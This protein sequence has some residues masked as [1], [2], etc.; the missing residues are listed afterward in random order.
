MECGVDDPKIWH[1]LAKKLRQDHMKTIHQFLSISVAKLS[2]GNT[3]PQSQ[4]KR[5]GADHLH[6][7][8]GNGSHPGM[9][10]SMPRN[11]TGA[12]YNV[13]QVYG[14][15]VESQTSCF[16]GGKRCNANGAMCSSA[17]SRTL[18]M[19]LEQQSEI[20]Y[21]QDM[22]L[23][24]QD[25]SANW[26]VGA[27]KHV[28]DLLCDPNIFFGIPTFGNEVNPCKGKDHGSSSEVREL[29][30]WELLPDDIQ[31]LVLKKL[32]YEHL[33]QA[34]LV[35]R[36]MKNV[37][38]SPA[39]LSSREGPCTEGLL[40]CL[41]F[42]VKDGPL[43]W[44]GFDLVLNE[45]RPLPTLSCL[46]PP[47]VDLFK[48][49]L[50]SASSGLLC[51]N[52]S[53]S[54][55]NEEELVVCN[56]MTQCSRI[57]PPLNFRRNPVLM[58]LL[59]DPK[60]NSYKVIVA[61]S[62]GMMTTEGHDVNLS[63]KTE[64]FDSLTSQWEVTGDMPGLEFGLNEYQTG[65]C[66]NGILY[67]ISY[68]EDGSG[69][70]AVAYD[71][72]AGDWLSDWRCPLPAPGNANS[73]LVECDGEVYLFSE[74]ENVRAVEHRIYKLENTAGESMCRWKHVV[75]DK[76]TG[77]RGLLVYPQ[78]A[79]VGFGAGKLCIF[80]TIEHTGKV[81]DIRN[82]GD[83]ELPPPPVMSCCKGGEKLFHSLNPLS[84]TFAPD[85]RTRVRHP[86]T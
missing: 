82:G 35:S 41:H 75:R 80:D 18:D 49:Y 51:A 72:A 71:V 56:P 24:F 31:G 12:D 30:S 16:A 48:D 57:L 17:N 6:E 59:T 70:G 67:C 1:T 14:E 77:G 27:L 21:H 7:A 52:V 5:L 36:G 85:F 29:N 42:C 69:K 68:L 8:N 83:F 62:S 45:W 64:V 74:H 9:P 66:I 40:A 37:I 11:I 79:C 10:N 32:K 2:T 44:S 86:Q 4:Q 63:R 55:H 65:V 34:K 84:F 38:E 81:H 19:T 46:P 22:T 26:A 53:K 33:F 43:Q 78:Y 73:Q 61:G 60:K 25:S 20:T 28:E 54:L 47:D 15:L 3:C 39:F 50:V 23:P 58:H 13:I 76:K